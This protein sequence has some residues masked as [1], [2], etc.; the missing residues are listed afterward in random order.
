[1]NR[2]ILTLIVCSYRIASAQSPTDR[3]TVSVEANGQVVT[4][5]DSYDNSSNTNRQYRLA[6]TRYLSYPIWEKGTIQMD[7]GSQELACELAFDMV[8]NDLLCRLNGDLTANHIAPYTF[9]IKGLRYYK[10]PIGFM[11]EKSHLYAT[12]VHDGPTQLQR[13]SRKVLRTDTQ[14][15]NGYNKVGEF[16]GYYAQKEVYL[17]RKGDARP[18]FIEPT[19][20]SLVRVLFEH[21]EQINDFIKVEKLSLE[22]VTRVL[23]YFDELVVEDRKTKPALSVEPVFTQFLHETILYPSQGWLNQLYARV[24]VGFEVSSTGQIQHVELLSPSNV[25]YNFDLSV[26]QGMKKYVQLRPEYAGRYVLPVAFTFANQKD[27]GKVYQPINKLDE[28]RL[29][30]RTLLDELIVSIEVKKP[31]SMAREVWGYYK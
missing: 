17:I 31:I 19:K 27:R 28:S 12:I 26:L 30:G 15:S 21:A 23:T 16:A 20:R 9:E 7:P 18:E 1:M 25:G 10:Q 22:E 13:T 2:Y 5:C 6:G 8:S 29:E 3:C 14:V 4:T 24:Y 11:G